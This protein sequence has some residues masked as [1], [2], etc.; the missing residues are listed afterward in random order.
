MAHRVSALIVALLLTL[1]CSQGFA[2][3]K[4][5]IRRAQQH[6]ANGAEKFAAGE[7]AKAVAEFMSGHA[8]APNAMFLY[9]VSLCYERLGNFDDALSAG[10]RAQEFEGM[11]PEVVVRNQARIHSFSVILAST[12]VAS[13]MS[14]RVE[15]EGTEV[16]DP[17]VTQRTTTKPDGVTVLGWSGVALAAVGVGL[18]LGGVATN[19]AIVADIETYEG[20]ARNGDS[21]AYERLGTDIANKQKTGK[22]LYGIG[23]G[24]AG[25]GAA[26]FVVDLFVGTKEVP[27]ATIS[28]VRGGAMVNAAVRF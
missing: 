4:D 13:E 1:A 22:L 14:A 25:L 3:S 11:P 2:Q 24:A 23:F 10:K 12:Q 5:D 18:I 21:A 19:S 26:L 6:F 15:T 20:A 27:V 7:Y 16:T 8:I 17:V 28:P 9:N